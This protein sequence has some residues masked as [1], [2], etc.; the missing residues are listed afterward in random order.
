MDAL[1]SPTLLGQLACLGAALLWA[2]ALTIFRR[3]IEIFGARRINLAKCSLAAVF[4]GLTVVLLGRSVDQATAADNP[5]I[6]QEFLD[7]ARMR[8]PVRQHLELGAF[9]ADTAM[10]L[11]RRPEAARVT[12]ECAAEGTHWIQADPDQL[13]Q[14][15]LNV[16][17]NGLEALEGRGQLRFTFSRGELPQRAL[18]DA[19]RSLESR[20]AVVVDPGGDV[21]VI[22]GVLSELQL[23]V[24]RIVHTHAHFDHI[25]GTEAL[26]TK[27]GAETLLHSGDQFLIDGFSRQGEMVEVKPG[28]AHNYLLPQG[29]AT[30]ASVHH[31]KMVEKHKTKLQA[32]QAARLVTR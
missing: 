12:I 28:F 3:P 32:I 17:L 25:Q 20:Q 26:R 4:Q 31:Q 24:V 16:G 23:T 18:T 21:D 6:I 11:A 10:L 8:P 13:R 9:V 30:V 15:F 5:R 22:L 2:I 19:G 1:D 7:F 14:A 29:L 27:T